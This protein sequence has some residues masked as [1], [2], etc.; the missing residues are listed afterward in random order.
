MPFLSFRAKHQKIFAVLFLGNGREGYRALCDAFETGSAFGAFD[1]ERGAGEPLFI[2]R[3]FPRAYQ[4][5]SMRDR[6]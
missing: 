3:E 5:R 6:C 1:K 4:T 2:K